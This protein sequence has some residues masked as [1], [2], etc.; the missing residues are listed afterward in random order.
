MST[1][2]TVGRANGHYFTAAELLAADFPEPKWA[3]PGLL[4]EGLNLLVG[5]PKAGKSWMALGLALAVASGGKALGNIP[6]EQGDVLYAALEDTKRRLQS[7]I[8]TVTSGDMDVPDRFAMA[9]D[10]GRGAQTVDL[11]DGWLTDHPDARLVIVDV[12]RKVTPQTGPGNAYE[13]DYLALGALKEV[14]D[15]H[16]VALLAVHHTRKMADDADVFNEVSGSTGITGAADAILI[17]KRARNTSEAVLHLT[18]RDVTEREYSLAWQPDN[19]TWSIL[20]A[21]AGAVELRDTRRQILAH[22]HE[23]QG[24]GPQRV[25]AALDLNLNTVKATMRRMIRDCQ[26]DTDGAGHYFPPIERLPPTG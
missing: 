5:A 6:V 8:L 18:G 21:P 15:R 25:A 3:V 22:L 9:T 2:E 4:A 1:L 20:D 12:L 16:R 17:V 7:R 23:H 26:L 24:E 10:I 14:A 11:L 19:C 13:A